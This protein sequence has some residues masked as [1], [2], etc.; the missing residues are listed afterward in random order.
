MKKLSL[1]V[2]IVPVI[3]FLT[4][5]SYGVG[6]DVERKADH[7][8]LVELREKVTTA[9]NNRDIK[10]LAVCFAKKFVVTTVDQSTIT[11][12]KGLE[13]YYARIFTGPDSLVADMKIEPKADVLTQFLDQNTGYCYGSSMD[14]YTLKKGIITVLNSRW[15]ATVIKEKKGWRIAAIHAGVNFLDNPVLARRTKASRFLI[16]TIFLAGFAIGMLVIIIFKRKRDKT[17]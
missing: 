1:K 7:R 13:E 4:V 15:T 5:L 10:N 8:L 14:T 9:I 16:S 2:L 11:S 17:D 12:E 3:M 6:V